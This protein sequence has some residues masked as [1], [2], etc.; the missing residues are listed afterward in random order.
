MVFETLLFLSLF[1][2]PVV[3]QT[4]CERAYQIP[5]SAA[6]VVDLQKLHRVLE[7]EADDAEFLYD[8]QTLVDASPGRRRTRLCPTVV[9]LERGFV[10]LTPQHGHRELAH[11]LAHE[12]LRLEE[13]F[14]RDEPLGS[15]F[16]DSRTKHT[17][18]QQ[19]ADLFSLARAIER[20]P[21]V[22]GVSWEELPD[23]QR[24]CP[25]CNPRP[26]RLA[27]TWRIH[28][29]T[30]Q[31]SDRQFA[32]LLRTLGIVVAIPEAGGNPDLRGVESTG[33]SA[34]AVIQIT[35]S[36]QRFRIPV[37][38]SE[39]GYALSQTFLHQHG[40]HATGTI[41][42]LYPDTLLENMVEQ[43]AAYVTHL[44]VDPAQV[45]E[46]SFGF[47]WTTNRW[48]PEANRYATYVKAVTHRPVLRPLARWGLR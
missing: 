45:T 37:R 12:P 16:A 22:R 42:H 36:D 18:R 24:F 3:E 31:M 33:G 44:R 17:I 34:P 15:L 23:H 6:D 26:E 40:L 38:P 25:L 35:A 39:A 46:T 21:R 20:D 30:W 41:Y 13:A 48:P 2:E 47:T 27:P 10:A 32:A 43:E 19:V 5:Q 9:R 4:V 14:H 7:P 11:W 29:P 8:I 28:Y 1:Q